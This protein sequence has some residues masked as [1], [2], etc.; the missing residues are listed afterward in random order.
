M[1][2]LEE[3]AFV[4]YGCCITLLGTMIGMSGTLLLQG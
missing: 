2:E 4:C 1:N 3:V